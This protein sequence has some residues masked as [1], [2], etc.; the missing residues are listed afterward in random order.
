[1]PTIFNRS[2]V[3]VLHF[4]GSSVTKR[5]CLAGWENAISGFQMRLIF[6]EP[7]N[8]RFCTA[9]R[10]VIEFLSCSSFSLLSYHFC[11]ELWFRC[12][13]LFGRI[14]RYEERSF[15]S[16]A[17]DGWRH[18]LRVTRSA[19]HVLDQIG[20]Q[21]YRTRRRSIDSSDFVHDLFFECLLAIGVPN[22]V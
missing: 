5:D 2:L 7:P 3:G 12:C 13:R 16:E 14:S 19:G 22:F 1:M 18:K 8:K 17:E 4:L 20:F 21:W 11:N 15:R 10:C 6:F 9:R